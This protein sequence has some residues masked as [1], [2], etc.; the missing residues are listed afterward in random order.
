M[1]GVRFSV[2][3]EPARHLP[4][5]FLAWINDKSALLSIILTTGIVE[6]KGL[7]V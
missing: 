2:G 6:R 5:L 1:A 3:L 4:R 7:M